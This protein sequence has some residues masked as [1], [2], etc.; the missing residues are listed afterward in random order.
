MG[1]LICSDGSEQADSAVRLGAAVGAACRAEV[2]LL[3]IVEMVSEST[4]VT[5]SLARLLAILQDKK[6]QAE[7]LTRTGKAI[8]QIVKRT[9]EMA[10]FL[11]GIG[12]VRNQIRGAVWTSSRSYKII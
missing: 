4:K 12:A 3:G 9:E 2:T 5:V 11:V 1:I 7:L 6:V 10:H 8:E